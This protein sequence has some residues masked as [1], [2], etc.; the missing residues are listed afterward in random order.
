[1]YRVVT[2]PVQLGHKI[3]EITLG[4]CLI[5]RSQIIEGSAGN[6]KEYQFGQNNG[7][8]AVNGAPMV[9]T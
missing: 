5:Y 7:L 3:Y 8:S 4:Q 2:S 1:M 6:S 9:Q